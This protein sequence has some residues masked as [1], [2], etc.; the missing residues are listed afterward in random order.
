MKN[1]L[2]NAAATV[3]TIAVLAAWVFTFIY[4]PLIEGKWLAVMTMIAAVALWAV[5]KEAARRKAE[6]ID[7]RRR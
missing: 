4:Q 2:L 6:R 5:L 1:K 3:L 7:Y